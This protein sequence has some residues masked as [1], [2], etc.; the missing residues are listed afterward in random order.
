MMNN[1]NWLVH[2]TIYLAIAV[3]EA[4]GQI[5]IEPPLLIEVKKGQEKCI[6]IDLPTDQDSGSHLGF[7]ALSADEPDE[8]RLFAIQT[9]E[10]SLSLNPKGD[11][12]LPAHVEL[13][14]PSSKRSD[15]HVSISG[16]SNQN[17]KGSLRL[18][19]PVYFKNLY[20]MDM[21]YDGLM[22]P[23]G[24]DDD[25]G[26]HRICFDAPGKYRNDDKGKLYVITQMVSSS[27]QKAIADWEENR[28]IQAR[29]DK[30][31]SKENYRQ[32]HIS[33]LEK[34]METVNMLAHS[35]VGDW[36]FL[37]KREERMRKTSEATQ[38]RVRTFSY[39]S[40]TILIASIIAQSIYLKVM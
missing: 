6:T 7:T 22:E 23:D 3:M 4:A 18:G 40:I 2:W 24:D 15:V 39:V 27:Q 20:S 19:E 9:M 8:V 30:E 37:E 32:K 36:E 26:M 28:K 5:P 38:S 12:Q 16:P 1:A 31:L 13:S 29:L 35:V 10:D 25:G 21:L 14:V 33:P 34:K 11:G 17:R